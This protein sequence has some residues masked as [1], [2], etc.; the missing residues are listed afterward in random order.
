MSNTGMVLVVV[1]YIST[2][3]T[4]HVSGRI[5]EKNKI[6]KFL[7]DEIEDEKKA[8]TR[9]EHEFIQRILLYMRLKKPTIRL[10]IECYTHVKSLF[11]R[12]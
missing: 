9:E 12:R 1:A 5:T 6:L 4:M 3:F 7:R 8:I 10:L 2:L 11:H